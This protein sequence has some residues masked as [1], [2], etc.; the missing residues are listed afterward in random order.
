M[1]SVWLLLIVLAS[2]LAAC[3]TGLS[4]S[5]GG[6]AGAGGTDADPNAT[7]RLE[8]RLIGLTAEVDRLS[9]RVAALEGVPPETLERRAVPPPRPRVEEPSVSEPP[10]REPPADVPASD[11]PPP[12]EPPAEEPDLD[13]VIERMRAEAPKDWTGILIDARPLG[14]DAP[15]GRGYPKWQVTDPE[16]VPIFTSEDLPAELRRTHP[17]FWVARADAKLGPEAL[18]LL[19]TTPYETFATGAEKVSDLEVR[20]EVSEEAARTL[21]G[22]RGLERILRAGNL[23]VLML[24]SE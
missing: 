22:Y 6:G 12:A 18:P 13:T 20:I 15:E 1:R 3:Q 17:V 5:R 7:A 23:A 21:R 8:A 10:P 4:R 9:R 2:G 16:G 14:S 11:P 19:G 24:K